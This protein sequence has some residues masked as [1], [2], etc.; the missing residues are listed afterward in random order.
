MKRC[1]GFA[2]ARAGSQVY[3]RM[4]GMANLATTPL[5]DEFLAPDV[6]RT[7]SRVLIDLSACQGMDSTFLGFLVALHGRTRHPAAR[8]PPDATAEVPRLVLVNPSSEA[9]RLLDMMGVSHLVPV[10]R[11]Q[12][13]PALELVEVFAQRDCPPRERAE[14]ILDAHRALVALSDA[15]RERF[16]GF[17]AALER[18]LYKL[19]VE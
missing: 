12:P 10:A 7:G 11:G 17:I 15:N 6:A 4:H 3:V 16:A 19:P 2:A 18:D 13:D 8:Q 14:L 9:T 5:L 1:H